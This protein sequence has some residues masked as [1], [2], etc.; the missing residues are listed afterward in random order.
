MRLQHS[1]FMNNNFVRT[2]LLCLVT[3]VAGCG[4]GGGGGAPAS[5]PAPTTPTFKDW[6]TASLIEADDTGSAAFP[7]IAFD[8]SGNAIAVWQQHDGT[9]YNIWANRYTVASGWGT[10]ELI[11]TD[12]AGDASWPRIVIDASGNAL[13]VWSQNNAA[14]ISSI[15][16]NRYTVGSGWGTAVMIETDTGQAYSVEI[17]GDARG[18]AMAVWTQ[19]D[20]T[21]FSIWAN[22][23]TAGS[24]WGIAEL[25]ETGNNGDAAQPQ[26]AI[27]PNGEAHAVW[28]Y[29]DGL[30]RGVWSNRFT[31][32]G[33]G[34]G[35][36]Q[37]VETNVGDA[38]YPQVVMDSN[39]R[40]FAVWVQRDD[41]IY[42]N[43]WA[44]SY[45]ASGWGTATLIENEAGDGGYPHLAVDAAGN[46][47]AVWR[48]F[49]DGNQIWSNRYVAASGGWGTAVPV[50]ISTALN[51]PT[52][53]PG[54]PVYSVEPRIAV[55]STGDALVVW[56][57]SDGDR[58]NIWS[59]RYTASRG[60]GT[61]ELLEMD[62]GASSASYPQ[63]AIDGDGNAIAVWRQFDGSRYN[64][65]ANHYQ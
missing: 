36:A 52:V 15:W 34:W 46:V 30:R 32:S 19:H 65:W 61:A 16:A 50:A 27:D 29:F 23:Y 2:L 33:T 42:Y 35:T 39:G 62:D 53:P 28:Q 57:Q 22:R 18:N 47:L 26:I 24:G 41:G 44:N 43:T 9:R 60:W 51:P 12:N 8:A 10:A 3:L 6:G 59:S 7:Q 1:R 48:L 58:Y 5:P 56:H 11:E 63:I 55:D 20:G 38:Y 14:A 49:N 31:V 25:I 45:T 64:V 17:A 37:R 54:I 4:G 21:R 40:A 13:A